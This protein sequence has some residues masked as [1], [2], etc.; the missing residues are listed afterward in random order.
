[1]PYNIFHDDH[2]PAINVVDGIE[3]WGK[4]K[5]E[6]DSM[7]ILGV[8]L[9]ELDAQACGLFTSEVSAKDPLVLDYSVIREIMLTT[10]GLEK[11]AEGEIS[12]RPRL[13]GKDGRVEDAQISQSQMEGGNCTLSGFQFFF[14]CRVHMQRYTSEVLDDRFICVRHDSDS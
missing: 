1:M 11:V 13:V 10:I 8:V 2:K 5:V 12:S 9:T 4:T 3:F 14:I 6:G 7:D